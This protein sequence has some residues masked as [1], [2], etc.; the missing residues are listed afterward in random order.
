M[1]DAVSMV[2]ELAQSHRR[3]LVKG[4]SLPDRLHPSEDIF[5]L[6]EDVR[7]DCV[8]LV[9]DTFTT[10]TRV[11]AAASVLQSA[12]AQVAGVVVIGRYVN[13]DYNVPVKKLWDELSEIPFDFDHCCLHHK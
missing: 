3:A 4:P 7:G 12:G 9:D 6:E 2:R 11:Q 1:E 5:Q 10:G 13:P 8:L